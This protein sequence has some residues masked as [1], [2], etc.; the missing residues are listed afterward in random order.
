MVRFKK[1]I[2]KVY[3]YPDHNVMMFPLSCVSTEHLN[4]FESVHKNI[5]NILSISFLKIL[6]A[7][8]NPVRSSS[9]QY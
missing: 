3:Q 8:N 7:K 4:N 5:T 9:D 6:G 1:K 2:S